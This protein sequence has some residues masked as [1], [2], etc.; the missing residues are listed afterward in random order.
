MSEKKKEKTRKMEKQDELEFTKIIKK[1][2][3]DQIPLIVQ[4]LEDGILERNIMFEKTKTGFAA[5]MRKEIDYDKTLNL[6]QHEIHLLLPGITI[7]L[8]NQF[9]EGK[10]DE[11]TFEKGEIQFIEKVLEILNED[12][13]NHILFLM[14]KSSNILLEADYEINAKEIY[15]KDKMKVYKQGILYL[16]NMV[17]VHNKRITALALSKIDVDYLIEK[18]GEIKEKIEGENIEH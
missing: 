13:K 9:F 11:D 3:A 17:D 6:E 8:Y 7:G 10:I 16:E 18:L 14:S 15:G 1:I 5:K 2:S 12:I 4:F